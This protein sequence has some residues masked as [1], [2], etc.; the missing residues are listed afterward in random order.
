MD[1]EPPVPKL[2]DEIDLRPR[3]ETEKHRALW[4]SIVAT[5]IIDCINM[6]P[7]NRHRPSAWRWIH[8]DDEG[9]YSFR[10]ACDHV[11]QDYLQ[12]RTILAENKDTR[13][14]LKRLRYYRYY[15]T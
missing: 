12:I 5:A 3:T 6:R 14:L 7:T 13:A 1:E 15:G 9:P 4:A 8:D 10:W 2:S 11:G